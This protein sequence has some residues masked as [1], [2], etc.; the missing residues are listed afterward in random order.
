MEK[1][2]AGAR[3][4]GDAEKSDLRLKSSGHDSERIWSSRNGSEVAG[5]DIERI[6]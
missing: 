2:I 1:S 6:F 5:M 3:N 4:E